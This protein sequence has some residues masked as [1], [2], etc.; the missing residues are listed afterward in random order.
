MHLHNKEV[1]ETLLGQMLQ[2]LANGK[3]TALPRAQREGQAAGP[4]A[5]GG[6]PLCRC[7]LCVA[8]PPPSPLAIAPASSKLQ[9]AQGPY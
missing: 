2:R 9:R 7:V 3:G 6:G 1:R 5:D 8:P 4:G